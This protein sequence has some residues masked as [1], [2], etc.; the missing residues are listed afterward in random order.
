[1]DSGVRYLVE[2]HE[3][4]DQFMKISRADIPTV[5]VGIFCFLKRYASPRVRCPALCVFLSVC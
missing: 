3:L 5:L 2:A 1:M 4:F